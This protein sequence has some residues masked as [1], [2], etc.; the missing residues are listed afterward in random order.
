MLSALPP[1]YSENA[2][3]MYQ[4][5]TQKE[6]KFSTRVSISDDAKDL[7]TKLLDKNPSKRFGKNSGFKEIKEHPFFK[8]IDFDEIL[9]KKI[10]APFIPEISGKLDVHNFDEEFTTEEIQMTQISDTGLNL[11]KKNVSKFKDFDN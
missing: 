1:F 9:N 11:I 7:I 5:I 3:K 2:E 8:G 4:M 10:K 6:L